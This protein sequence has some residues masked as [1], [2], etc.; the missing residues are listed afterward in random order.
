MLALLSAASCRKE[1]AAAPRA[2]EHRGTVETVYRELTAKE[3]KELIERGEV[4]VL[5]VRT[6]K[7]FHDGHLK[8]AKL[9]PVQQ[10]DGRASE[11]EEHEDKD[12]LLY[13][14]SG[15]R[16]TVAAEILRRRGFRRLHNMRHG[17]RGW[18]R[19]GYEIIR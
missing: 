9:I 4:L 6:P 19:E 12:I 15:N 18:L 10:L 2:P 11:I 8:G 14:R 5:D 7:E 3:A 17:I 13:C 1:R 16:S